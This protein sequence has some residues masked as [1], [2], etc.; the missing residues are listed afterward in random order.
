LLYHPEE[1]A[2]AA[3]CLDE[4]QPKAEAAGRA[5][6]MGRRKAAMVGERRTHRRR[7]RPSRTRSGQPPGIRKV[8]N[9]TRAAAAAAAAAA[10]GVG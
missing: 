9:G 3:R 7:G 1:Q 5:L 4:D 6:S 8:E 10:S 2:V